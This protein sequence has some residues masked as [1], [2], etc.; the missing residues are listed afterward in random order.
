MSSFPLR[1]RLVLRAGFAG[2]REL[3]DSETRVLD[4]SLD[5][6]LSSLGHRLAALAPGVPYEGGAVPPI[7]SFYSK[8][9][10]LL[11]LITGL[12]EGADDRAS[13]ALDRL[14]GHC[15]LP[16]AGES[17]IAGCLQTELGVVLP[18]RPEVYRRSRS[19][20]YLPRFD[21]LLARSAWV[22][23]L[24]GIYD[25]PAPDTSLAKRRRARAYR[26]QSAVLLR[27][28]DL[29]IAA[30]NP[31]DDG[32]AGGT[33][34]TVREAQAFDLPVI[35]IHTGKSRAEEAIYLIEPEDLI[36]NVLAGE[37]PKSAERTERLHAWINYLTADPDAG[38]TAGSHQAEK[39][40]KY[41]EQVLKEFFDEPESPEA[42]EARWLSRRRKAA[43]VWFEGWF[44]KGPK[45]KSDPPLEPY[46]TYRRRA[47]RLNYH[48]TGLYRGAFI[49]NYAVAITAV[50]LAA[51]SLTL[52]G[53][54]AHT[55]LAEQVASVL[56][57]AGLEPKDV[58]V[59][60][61]QQPWLVPV[62]IALAAGKM[63][64]LFFIFFNTKTANDCHWNDRAID[65]RY[66]AERLRAMF[67]LP[68]VGSQQPP[69]AALPQFASRAVRQ[70][71]VDWLFD[72]IV[73]SVSP[74]DLAAAQPAQIP[75]HDGSSTVQIRHL[76]T[77]Q[78]RQTI[79][80][81]R[82]SWIT[83]QADYHEGNTQTM[84]AMHHGLEQ[85]QKVLGWAVIAIVGFD[86]VLLGIKI[87][88]WPHAL[89]GFAKLATPWLIAASAI[90]PAVV[91]AISGIRFQSECQA[92]AERSDVMRSILVGREEKKTGRYA[93]A[94]GLALSIAEQS[95]NPATEVGSWSHDV[96]RFTEHLAT[97]FVQE[98]AEWSVVYA[99]EVSE[100]G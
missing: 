100:P 29:L 65:T 33:M 49:L 79:A 44:K 51:I 2:R 58:A 14:Q 41:G 24:D 3:T 54:A 76:L 20:A 89:Y 88:H 61:Q 98:A 75:S 81:V 48:Y 94:D 12:C 50:I 11:R 35:F 78:P 25:K 71:A 66:L 42:A 26:A 9:C 4:E 23:A 18:F 64:L 22:I 57:A 93:Q 43:W 90:L 82:D 30:A 8:D 63:G 1:P 31:D 38:L 91:A 55:P 97:D 5:L 16:Q 96:L 13:L 92:L 87:L 68:L 80:L 36:P 21:Q 74:A 83:V 32:R 40:R 7:T 77:P 56:K 67:Y 95:S 52:L 19:T 84:H 34:E 60:P 73:R 17:S 15:A 62:L 59:N 53:T 39:A 70:S 45:A 10:P 72:A 28:S 69:A 47:T 27:Q 37:A 46:A 85:W 6:I 99:K 86:L